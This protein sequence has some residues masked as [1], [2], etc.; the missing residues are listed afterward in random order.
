MADSLRVEQGEECVVGVFED[1]SLARDA[2][3]ALG[4]SGFAKERISLVAADVHEHP[5]VQQ[6][7][8]YGDQT[9]K[10]AAKGAGVGGLVGLLVGGT[11]LTISGLGPVFAAGYIA[12]TLTGAI[13]GAFLGALSGWGVHKDHIAEY[14]ELVKEGKTLVMYHGPPRE[15]ADAERVLQ[16]SQ[17]KGV[18]LHAAAADESPE[19]DD[20]PRK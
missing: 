17:A 6:I 11:A 16:R 1:F 2:V 10:D 12:S 15:T 13:A 20:R 5:D 14:E 18:H 8:Q 19:V 3:L 4:Q 7:L 9:T